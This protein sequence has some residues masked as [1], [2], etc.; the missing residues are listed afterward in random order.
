MKVMRASSS[1]FTVVEALV[2]SALLAVIAMI[3]SRA[4]Q[5]FSQDNEKLMRRLTD[6]SVAHN[7]L[8]LAARPDALRSLLLNDP[9]NSGLARCLSKGVCPTSESPV[10]FSREDEHWPFDMSEASLSYRGLPH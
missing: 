8:Q 5:H 3:S 1:G 4:Y 7:F 2:G 10:S 6:A 9:S